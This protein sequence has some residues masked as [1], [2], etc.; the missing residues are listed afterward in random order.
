MP[1]K[2]STFKH[3]WSWEVN[4]MLAS[5]RNSYCFPTLCDAN[6]IEHSTVLFHR[7]ILPRAFLFFLIYA[8]SILFNFMNFLYICYTK[9]NF[10]SVTFIDERLGKNVSLGQE[11]QFSDI[12][13]II[14]NLQFCFWLCWKIIT[15]SDLFDLTPIE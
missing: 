4:N 12:H 5:T 6:I 15:F 7:R 11:I 9:W 1:R 10:F 14:S 3:T 2:D 8:I 13:L